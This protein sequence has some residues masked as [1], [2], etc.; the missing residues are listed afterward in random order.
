MVVHNRVIKGM[1]TS[2]AFRGRFCLYY[3]KAHSQLLTIADRVVR[4]AAYKRNPVY[5]HPHTDLT[6]Q[7]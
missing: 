2:N 7:L 5:F 1:R 6:R 4:S 3:H